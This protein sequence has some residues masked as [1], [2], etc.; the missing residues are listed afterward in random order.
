MPELAVLE[1]TRGL[2]V[3]WSLVFVDGGRVREEK[4]ILLPPIKMGGAIERGG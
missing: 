4:F 1:V 2:Y 3:P